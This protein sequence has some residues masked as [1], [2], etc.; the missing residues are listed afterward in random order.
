MLNPIILNNRRIPKDEVLDLLRVILENS[1][2]ITGVSFITESNWTPEEGTP[3]EDMTTITI[4]LFTK[5]TTQISSNIG[6]SV[7]MEPPHL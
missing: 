4:E 6:P 5:H 2:R 1:T 3:Q 7:L